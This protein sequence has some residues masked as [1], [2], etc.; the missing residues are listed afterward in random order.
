M[1]ERAFVLTLELQ[2]LVVLGQG[3]AATD[4]AKSARI[5]SV[6]ALLAVPISS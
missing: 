1:T 2:R 3:A 4:G 6:Y 5:R